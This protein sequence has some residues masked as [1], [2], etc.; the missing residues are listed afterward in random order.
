MNFLKNEN[1]QLLFLNLKTKNGNDKNNRIFAKNRNFYK[2]NLTN[3]NFK[4]SLNIQKGLYFAFFYKFSIFLSFLK[5]S[6]LKSKIWAIKKAE[7]LNLTIKLDIPIIAL[8]GKN[9]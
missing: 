8:G 3:S 1:R 4:I 2:N 9:G 6:G 7:Y 5:N